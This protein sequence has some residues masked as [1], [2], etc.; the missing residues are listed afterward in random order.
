MFN[1][2]NSISKAIIN[3]KLSNEELSRLISADISNK[4][5]KDS[6]SN[7]N[8]SCIVEWL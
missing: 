6:K 2:N 8:Y 5:K 3:M 7:F 4:N 1:S